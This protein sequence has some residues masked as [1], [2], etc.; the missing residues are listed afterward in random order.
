M[1]GTTFGPESQF[2]PSNV[3]PSR[4]R[5][6]P[7]PPPCPE[8]AA[9][10]APRTAPTTLAPASLNSL[11]EVARCQ[12]DDGQAASL[13]GESLARYR[14]LGNKWGVASALHKI[15]P[16]IKSPFPVR[17]RATPDDAQDYAPFA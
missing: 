6:T 1:E 14:E 3:T 9:G 4:G 10:T 12:G 11:G 13:Y 5:A 8:P 16:I 15:F 7:S 17:R 2:G